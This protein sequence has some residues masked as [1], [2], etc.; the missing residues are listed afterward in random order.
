M[1]E[2]G[3]DFGE[4]DED[5]EIQNL[6]LY[7][8]RKADGIYRYRR[9]VPKNLVERVGK[10]Y[11]YR[12]LGRTKKDVVGNWPEAHAEVEAILD[13]PQTSAEKS[14]ELIKRKDHRATILHLVEEKY[15][16]EAAQRLEVG[17]VDDN[18]EYA[19]M[20]LADRLEGLYPKKTLALL[21]VAVLPE[22]SFSF[23]DVL[24]QYTEFKTTGYDATDHRLKV[25]IAK[26][27]T[28]LEAAIGA[29]KVYQQPVQAITRQ[30]AN[31][32]RDSLMPVMAP[33]SVAR[34]KN[35]LNAALNW[36]IKE[37]GI[38]W[39]SPFAGLL[40]KG[41]GSSKADRHPLNVEQV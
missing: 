7:T 33:N 26:C 36:Y 3:E 22:R 9:R 4:Q 18:L 8:E 28:D 5:T 29:F 11:L 17:A 16:K 1:R 2:T 34:Y 41:A 10:G 13:G 21:H 35:T 38:D 14:A 30:D 23:A 25:R 39:T 27:K 15:G 12:N 32:Y 24:D 6:P 19:L 40:I 20:A 37:T 31:A